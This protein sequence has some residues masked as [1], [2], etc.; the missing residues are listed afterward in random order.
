MGCSS[1]GSLPTPVWI[2]E[3]QGSDDAVRELGAADSERAAEGSGEGGGDAERAAYQAAV[4]MYQAMLPIIQARRAEN[5]RSDDLLG[6][7]LH[8]SRTA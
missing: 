2:S 6:F 5:R 8:W 1:G 3:R 4:Q 7:L